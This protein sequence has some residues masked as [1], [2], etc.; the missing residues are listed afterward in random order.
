MTLVPSEGGWFVVKVND[1]MVYSK[2]Q[3][4]RHPEPGEVVGLVRK[5]IK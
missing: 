2:L 4:H 3:T 1:R 5:I